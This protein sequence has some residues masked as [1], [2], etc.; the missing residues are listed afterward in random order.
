MNSLLLVQQGYGSGSLGFTGEGSLS[1]QDSTNSSATCAAWMMDGRDGSPGIGVI[2][3]SPR[4]SIWPGEKG[5]GERG[6]LEAVAINSS[7]NSYQPISLSCLLSGHL[8]RQV[9]DSTERGSTVYK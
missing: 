3:E 9:R 4:P 1:K 5:L 8:A 6:L 7:Y 2:M